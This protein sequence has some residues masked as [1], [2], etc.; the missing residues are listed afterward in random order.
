VLYLLSSA[1]SACFC[2]ASAIQRSF[3]VLLCCSCYQALPPFSVLLQHGFSV[4]SAIQRGFSVAL[5][6]LQHS[7]LLLLFCSG[8]ALLQRFFDAV[9]TW[10]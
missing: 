2:V 7:A 1:A 3:I 8:Q 4:A 9:K 10:L 5:A 6:L